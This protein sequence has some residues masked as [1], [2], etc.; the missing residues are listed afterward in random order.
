MAGKDQSVRKIM[1]NQIRNRADAEAKYI[2][3]TGNLTVNDYNGKPIKVL[4]ESLRPGGKQVSP[5]NIYFCMNDAVVNGYHDKPNGNCYVSRGAVEKVAAYKLREGEDLSSVPLQYWSSEKDKKT[6]DRFVEAVNA[7]KLEKFIS[8]NTE[9]PEAKRDE[10]VQA[11]LNTFNK[12][13]NEG[14]KEGMA[15]YDAVRDVAHIP[16]NNNKEQYQKDVC[17]VVAAREASRQIVRETSNDRDWINGKFDR[18]QVKE[19][20]VVLKHCLAAELRGKLGLGADSVNGLKRETA[21]VRNNV[22]A[23]IKRDVGLM[24]QA[25]RRAHAIASRMEGRHFPGVLKEVKNERKN[26]VN[27]I[28]KS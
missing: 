5:D 12:V 4:G 20:S 22:V 7:S 14:T 2:E 18:E 16:D 28:E 21:S 19:S 25:Q 9:V 13:D 26:E 1:Q 27:E 15:W 8:H 23:A 3:Q 17:Y 11:L 6:K 24:P 10:V